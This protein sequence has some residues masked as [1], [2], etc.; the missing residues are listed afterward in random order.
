[1]FHT[2]EDRGFLFAT[3]YKADA[4]NDIS[5]PKDKD[6]GGGQRGGGKGGK[7]NNR[8]SNSRDN[9]LN[10]GANQVRG[11]LPRGT[12]DIQDLIVTEGS[13]EPPQYFMN[14]Q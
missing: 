7:G 1:M 6:D 10:I 14:L 3:P 12:L 2:F 8:D 11:L 4:L 13:T 9:G 5:K